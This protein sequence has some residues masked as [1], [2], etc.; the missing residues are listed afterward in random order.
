MRLP[1]GTILMHRVDQA[2]DPAKA[3]AYYERTKKL[4]GRKPRAS[5]TTVSRS[6]GQPTAAARRGAKLPVKNNPNLKKQRQQAAA[7]V[8]S[9]QKTLA[10]LHKALKE[11]MAE[12]KKSEAKSKKS[13]KEAAKPDTA[14]EKSKKARESKKFRDTHK[15]ELKTDAKREQAKSGGSSGG[16]KSSNKEGKIS[17]ADSV[18]EI[19]KAI[20][21]V[22]Q[23]L[24]AAKARQRALG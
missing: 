13:A 11:K 3:H 12:A 23:A 17:S 18:K 9:L 2:Y 22:Q 24:T 4:K 21:G 14:A 19:K 16:S 8:A 5:T 7:R 20:S 6:A 1:D 10:S 15:Q